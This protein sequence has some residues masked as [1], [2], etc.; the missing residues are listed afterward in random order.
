MMEKLEMINHLKKNIK[1]EISK[2][3]TCEICKRK[4]ANKAHLFRHTLSSEIHKNN[5]NT[6]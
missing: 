2:F 1:I 4:F 3:V 5:L 6:I